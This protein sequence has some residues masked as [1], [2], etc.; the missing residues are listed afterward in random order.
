MASVDSA[1][2]SAHQR[3]SADDGGSLRRPVVRELRPCRILGAVPTS[4]CMHIRRYPRSSSRAPGAVVRLGSGAFLRSGDRQLLERRPECPQPKSTIAGDRGCCAAVET[5]DR[6]QDLFPEVAFPIGVRLVNMGL[7]RLDDVSRIL[8]ARTRT[9]DIHPTPKARSDC[10]RL[11][12]FV[13]RIVADH[14]S[15]VRASAG[16]VSRPPRCRRRKRRADHP[17]AMDWVL[18][19][20]RCKRTD[21]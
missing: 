2:A 13:V 10:R 15:H 6:R 4:S 8:A 16:D 17:R 9:G 18:Q 11:G 1:A 19:N 14:R 5:S 7:Q 21:R 12:V 20:A 3:A